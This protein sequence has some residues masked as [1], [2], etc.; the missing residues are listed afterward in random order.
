M[1]C[2]VLVKGLKNVCSCN[3]LYLT[4]LIPGLMAMG[5]NGQ[6]S[7]YD[8]LSVLTPYDNENFTV[9]RPKDSIV[10]TSR[11]I[12]LLQTSISRNIIVYGGY[13]NTPFVFYFVVRSVN[14]R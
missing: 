5:Q 8:V 6:E 1:T 14:C 13:I 10:L 7:N 3:F 4:S 12:R 9:F 11:E 2:L